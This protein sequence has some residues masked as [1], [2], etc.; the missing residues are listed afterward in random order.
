MYELLWLKNLL[1]KFGFKLIS[2]MSMY[3]DNKLSSILLKSDISCHTKHIE[4]DWHLVWNIIVKKLIG[5][6]FT[7]SLEQL[8]NVLTKA[9]LL[10]VFSNL[11]NKL[12][13]IDIYIPIWDGA[14]D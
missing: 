7:S 6:P 9:A 2:P 13:M 8:A 4:L 12:G 10:V 5:T 3:C 1:I 14:L 11:Y